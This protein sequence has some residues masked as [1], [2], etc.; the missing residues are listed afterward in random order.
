MTRL[1]ASVLRVAFPEPQGGGSA[2]GTAL[3]RAPQT[4]KSSPTRDQREA[5]YRSGMGERTPSDVRQ[6]GSPAADRRRQQ[7]PHTGGAAGSSAR[8]RKGPRR[9][10]AKDGSENARAE[11]KSIPRRRRQK[12]Q[13]HRLKN[14]QGLEGGA[15]GGET[16]GLKRRQSS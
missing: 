15:A 5:G 9:M 6:Q 10:A 12:G 14:H 1:G 3:C 2:W 4:P 7:L 13:G 11:R 16:A 8:G